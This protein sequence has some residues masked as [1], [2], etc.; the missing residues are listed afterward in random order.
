M[1]DSVI[2]FGVVCFQLLQFLVFACVIRQFIISFCQV[3]HSVLELC[4]LL[5]KFVNIFI[6]SGWGAGSLTRL[7]ESIGEAFSYGQE[8]DV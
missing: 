1:C 2:E 5:P 3:V 4:I 8:L 6:G 7:C